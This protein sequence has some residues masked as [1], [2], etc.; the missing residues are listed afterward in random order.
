[1]E[2]KT[3]YEL[4]FDNK[5]DLSCLRE[6]GACM[7]ILLQGPKE[8]CKMLPKSMRCIYAGHEDGPWAIK[9][10]VAAEMSTSYTHKYEYPSEFSKCYSHLTHTCQCEYLFQTVGTHVWLQVQVLVSN[11]CSHLHLHQMGTS[12]HLK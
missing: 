9:Y 2:E 10:Y 8:P 7:W 1:M 6:F 12:T 4:W 5:L 3:P 11:E